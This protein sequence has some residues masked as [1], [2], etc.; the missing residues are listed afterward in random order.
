M[1]MDL[2]QKFPRAWR[3]RDHVIRSTQVLGLEPSPSPLGESGSGLDRSIK[4]GGIAN[5]GNKRNLKP[6]RKQAPGHQP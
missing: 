2:E 5:L 4:T 1:T 6:S 3:N